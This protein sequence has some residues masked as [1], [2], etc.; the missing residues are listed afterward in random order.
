LLL[1]LLAAVHKKT[2]KELPSGRSELT[3]AFKITVMALGQTNYQFWL[4]NFWDAA[5]PTDLRK[6]GVIVNWTR[7]DVNDAARTVD[8]CLN[9]APLT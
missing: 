2:Y 3:R 7:N 4:R 5:Y 1:V 8:Q 9:F 6:E